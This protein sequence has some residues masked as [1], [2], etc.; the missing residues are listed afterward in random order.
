MD[1]ELD[2][3]KINETEMFYFKDPDNKQDVLIKIYL[4]N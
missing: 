2:V 3:G 4:T 1:S